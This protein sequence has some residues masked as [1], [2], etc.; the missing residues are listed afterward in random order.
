MNQQNRVFGDWV[1]YRLRVLGMSQGQLARS[2]GMD[3]GNLSR[4][5]NGR[6]IPFPT[7]ERAKVF[8]AAL[9]SNVMDMMRYMGYF[10]EDDEERPPEAEDVIAEIIVRAQSLDIPEPLREA[11][12]GVV[13]YVDLEIA[14]QEREGSK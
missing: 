10:D 1:R 3:Q 12:I 13:K 11:I 14:K 7:P 4:I 8:A 2:L 9:D 6:A 5:M